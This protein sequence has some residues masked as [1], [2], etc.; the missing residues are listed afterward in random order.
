LAEVTA[1]LAIFLF[2]TAEF[3][4]CAGPTLLRGT[5]RTVA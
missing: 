4:S 1:L 3:F 5:W 2:V